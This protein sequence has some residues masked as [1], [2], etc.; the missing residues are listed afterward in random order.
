MIGLTKSH[1]AAHRVV[2]LASTALVALAALLPGAALAQDAT[3]LANPGTGD[4]NTAANWNPASVPTG[5]AFFATPNTT[6]LSF[7]VPTT[8]IGGWTFNSGA[9]AY[10]FSN[11]KGLVF[12]GAGIVINGGSATTTNNGTG[13]I[14]FLANSTA[15]SATINSFGSVFFNDTSTAGSATITNNGHGL[16]AFFDNSTAG[17]ASII[18]GSSGT[19][20]FGGTSTAGSATV[21]NQGALN[22]DNSG[23]AGSASITNNSSGNVAFF[24]ISTA[25]SAT[26][27]NTFGHVVFDD[28]ST[29]SNATIGNDLGILFKGSSTAG[30]ASITNTG[31]VDF[32]DTST[33]GSASITSNSSG[34]TRFFNSAGGGSAR[35]VLN[36]TGQ[37]DISAL[38]SAGTTAGSIEGDGFVLLG[39]KNL[40][41]GGNDL[42]TNFAGVIG[43]TGGSVTKTGAGTLTLAGVNTYTGPTVADGGILSVNGS[44]AASSLTTVNA[45]GTL[46]GNGIVGNT[47]INGGALAPGHSI[48]LLTVQGSLAFT[49]ASSYLVEVSPATADRVNVTGT[50]ALGGATVNVTFAAGTYLA[51][52]YA[53]L[54]AAGGISGT[55]GTE[56]ESNAPGNFQSALSYDANNAYL[57][58]T[59]ALGAGHGLNINQRNVANS[60]NGFFNGGGALPPGF[61]HLFGLTGGNLTTALTQASGETATGAQKTTFDAMNLFM[62][63]LTD[64]FVAGR[65]NGVSSA[66][67]APAQFAGD[68]AGAAAANGGRSSSERDAYAAIDRKAPVAAEPFAQRWSVWAAG[69]GGAQ[70]TDGNAALGSNTATSRIA[71]GAVGADFRLSPFTL[72]GFALAGGGT[73][74]SIAGG[75][76]SGRSDLFQAGAFLRH[77]AGPTYVSAALAYGWQD[78]TTDRTVS[79]AGI[80]QLRARFNANAWSGRTEGG[81]R[82]VSPWLG[83][84]GITPYA[85]GQFTTFDLPAYAE[86][87]VVGSS[88]FALAYGARNVT[89]SRSELGLRTDQSFAMADGVVILRGRAAWAH[90]FNPDRTI[91]AT[92]QALPGASFAVNGAAQAHDAGLVTASAEK[93]WLNGWSAAA[94]F[95]GEFSSVTRSYAGKGVVRYAW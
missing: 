82:F 6:N 57:N 71:A 8:T 20:G 88:T 55:F 95:E 28:T 76:G 44:I 7:S 38:T 43:G 54:N 26:I 80:D 89:A 13:T 49:M 35:F 62:G 23:T 67:G 51:K 25:G 36:G 53:I 14:F 70:T 65:D 85:A 87:A 12:T 47:M 66:S 63:V 81:Y 68:G 3:W 29:A 34:A 39:A 10:T 73:N 37:L 60:I 17:G 11:S 58:L 93:A 69:F 75:L 91:A 33:A 79:I 1:A 46:G 32:V 45:G 21:N 48:G 52:R 56:V 22:F 61:V 16:V 90:D 83:G 50:A 72:A 27:N 64:P 84:I 19:V 4:F 77:I 42:S 9:S 2:L 5:T 30:G 78:I 15:S 41:V 92:F 40:A 59:A 86:Q 24:K 31:V 94:T 18:N 74:F